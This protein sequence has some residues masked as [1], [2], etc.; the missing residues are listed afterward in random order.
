MRKIQ[1]QFC[2][3][4]TKD[5][6]PESNCEDTSDKYK[7]GDILENRLSSPTN[8]KVI[9]VK[10]RLKNVP[11]QRKLGAS[12]VAEWLSSRALLQWPGIHGFR[13]WAWT[14]A[15]LIKPCCGGIPHRRTRMT[16]N[17]DIQ[18]GTGALGRKK[19]KIGNRCQ[20]RVNLP[21][22]EKKS[23]QKKRKLKQHD[24]KTQYILPDWILPK[25][26]HYWAIGE[27]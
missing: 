18:V 12:P 24:T 5:A 21:H 14:Y 22:Q 11:Y 23:I 19:R 27:T 20:L 1:H 10:E 9:K 2:D 26:G 4:S 7:W 17:Q 15:L 3:I 13:S 6:Q 8:V 16:Y 25:K